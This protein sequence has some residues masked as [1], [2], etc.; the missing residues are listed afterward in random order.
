MEEYFFVVVQSDKTK[1]GHGN[2]TQTQLR[3][4]VF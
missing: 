4:L 2:K 3:K 1:N